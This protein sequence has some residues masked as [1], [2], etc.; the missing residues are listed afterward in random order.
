[1]TISGQTGLIGFEA[2]V[3]WHHPW[4]GLLE[5]AQFLALAEQSGLIVPIGDWVIE[6]ALDQIR[7]WR[8]ARP[9]VSISVN[10]SRRQLADP[11]FPPASRGRSSAQTATRACSGWRSRPTR[12]STELDPRI[13]T[14]IADL[15]V[16]IA[17]DG[18]GLVRATLGDLRDFPVDMLKIDRRFVRELDDDEDGA[19]LIGAVVEL[20]HTLGLSV[21]AAGVETDHQLAQL[22]DLGCDGAQGFLFSQPVPEESVGEMLGIS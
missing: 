14:E 19:A 22:R 12:C 15:G 2:L 3:R 13:V 18:F 6:Q 7:H 11:G 20:G 16:N 5:P 21:V 10:V 17:I 8:Q 1:M 9:G 4:R